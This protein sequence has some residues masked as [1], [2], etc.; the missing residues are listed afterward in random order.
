MVSVLQVCSCFIYNSCIVL[1]NHSVL[2][3]MYIYI[4]YSMQYDFKYKIL[5]RLKK[6]ELIP[7]LKQLGYQ[8]CFINVELK[9]LD[10]H[11]YVYI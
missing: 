2:Y 7:K 10:I 5:K 8:N 1:D 11:I 4:L 3:I 6:F 9:F